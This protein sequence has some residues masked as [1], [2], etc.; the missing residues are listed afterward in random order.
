MP[1]TDT[2]DAAYWRGRAEE[3]RK[4]ATQL[5]D[6]TSQDAMWRVAKTYDRMADSAE[7]RERAQPQ[8]QRTVSWAAD[9]VEIETSRLMHIVSFPTYEDLR[10]WLVALIAERPNLNFRAAFEIPADASEGHRQELHALGLFPPAL[11]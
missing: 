3:A 5:I 4:V 10:L 2:F 1:K 6:L 11:T 9:I 8:P 7:M